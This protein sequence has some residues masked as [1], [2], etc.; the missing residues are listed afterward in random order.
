M[1]ICI[2]QEIQ[3]D[4]HRRAETALGTQPSSWTLATQ[5]QIVSAN[6][7]EQGFGV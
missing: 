1:L 4:I 5:G 7:A 6:Q 2:Y 3:Q